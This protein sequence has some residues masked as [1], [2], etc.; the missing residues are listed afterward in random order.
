MSRFASVM[1]LPAN[2]REQVERKLNVRTVRD[3]KETI[4]QPKNKYGARRVDV[5]VRGKMVRFDSKH[6]YAS[7]LKLAAREQAGEIDGLEVHVKFGLCDSDGRLLGSYRAD[8]FYKENGKT[9]VA[10]AKS[11]AT[12]AKQDWRR[13]KQLMRICWGHDVIEI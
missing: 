5:A 1:D 10:D 9:K 7:Y 12:R 8:F 4:A 13:T 3:G 11:D 6:E 2:L